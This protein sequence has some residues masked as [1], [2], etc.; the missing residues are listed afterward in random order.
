MRN[1]MT[2]IMEHKG[3]K[4][5]YYN[6]SKNVVITGDHVCRFY[7][8]C[9]GRM[10]SGNRSVEDIWSTRDA[11]SAVG[12]IKESMPQDAFKD[13]CRCMHF[14]DDWEEDD[15]RWN[16]VYADDKEAVTE[17][18]ARHRRK[19]GT[20]EGGYTNRWQAMVIFGREMTADESRVA[21]WYHSPMTVGPEPKPI[22]TGATFHSLCMTKGR[23]RTY[24]L[25]VR[26]YGGK[27]DEDLDGANQ[28]TETMQKWV[29]LY[30]IMLD[31]F[32]GV[33]RNV[34]MDSAYMGD[35]MALIGRH[36]WLMNMVGTTN[37]NRTGAEAKEERKGMKKCNYKTIFFQHDDE[38][39]LYALW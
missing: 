11:F 10:L 35:I 37:E 31:P 4:P 20:L 21:G 39:L 16:E 7:G 5:K 26:A 6:P 9:I 22:R 38:P 3:Y 1:Y 15:E 33:G 27:S 17:G 19:F 32:K 29:N 28:H 36:E 13:L 8:I 23:L 30:D 24:K 25:W 2:Y 12:P 18:T 34:T 14:A